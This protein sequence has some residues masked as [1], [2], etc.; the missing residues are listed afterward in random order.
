MIVH[1][2]WQ[3]IDF[4][5]T[6]TRARFEELNMDL[7][8]RCMEPVEKVLRVRP[9]HLYLGGVI[10]SGYGRDNCVCVCHYLHDVYSKVGMPEGGC[11]RARKELRDFLRHKK[12]G[13]AVH[14]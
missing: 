3:G 8:R 1:E 6:I 7:F 10:R 4:Y 9:P 2:F 11:R 12:I 14:T 5:A 13:N